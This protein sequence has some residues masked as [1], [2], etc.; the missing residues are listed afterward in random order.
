M[1]PQTL[2]IIVLAVLL[3]L[4]TVFIIGV[5]IGVKMSRPRIM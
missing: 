2:T 5:M 4:L 3:I 1:D